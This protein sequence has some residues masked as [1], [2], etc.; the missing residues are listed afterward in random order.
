MKLYNN[1]FDLMEKAMDLRVKRHALISSNIANSETPNFVARE[2]DF[3]GELDKAVGKDNSLLAKTDSRHLDL[4]DLQSAHSV[5]DYS[6]AIGADGNNVDL[7][8]QTSKLAENFRGYN[9]AISW[10]GVQLRMLKMAAR[11]RV[12]S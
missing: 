5:A 9:N 8:L 4:G 10:L 7:D 11:G 3:A 2:L 1:T 12:G 6:G